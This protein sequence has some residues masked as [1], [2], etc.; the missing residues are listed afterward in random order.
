MRENGQTTMFDNTITL[1]PT[2]QISGNVNADH[3][4][5][6][7]G[8]FNE[9]QGKFRVASTALTLQQIMLIKHDVRTGKGYKYQASSVRLS[10]TVLDEVS[11]K[12]L[13]YDFG[14]YLNIPE[15][16][17]AGAGDKVLDLQG[18]GIAFLRSLT[19]LLKMQNQEA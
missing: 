14:A 19:Y 15:G 18:R 10:D 5:Q 17:Y 9:S 11:G 7:V 4:Y 16:V 13:T 3:V 2:G 12:P 1:N 8:S 6:R